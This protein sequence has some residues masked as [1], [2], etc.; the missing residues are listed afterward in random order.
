MLYQKVFNDKKSKMDILWLEWINICGTIN[1]V[2]FLKG[3]V[4]RF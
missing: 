1:I 2:T 3:N 4:N